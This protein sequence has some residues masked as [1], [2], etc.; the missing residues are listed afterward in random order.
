MHAKKY[1][2]IV[3]KF[4]ITVALLSIVAYLIQYKVLD[5][6]PYANFFECIA[7]TIVYIT[8]YDNV[9][10][11]HYIIRILLSIIG[12]V[13]LALLG[14]NLTVNLFCRTKDV[15]IIAPDFKIGTDNVYCL[16]LGLIN[17]GGSICNA[18]A[19][20]SFY[21]NES[22]TCDGFAVEKSNPFIKG[23]ASWDI[24]IPVHSGTLFCEYLRMMLFGGM[25]KRM[26][27]TYTYV[28][29]ATG[30]Q[31]IRLMEY[32]ITLLNIKGLSIRTVRLRETLRKLLTRF[33]APPK[34]MTKENLQ[35][36]QWLKRNTY[37]LKIMDLKPVNEGI[38]DITKQKSGIVKAVVDFTQLNDKGKTD[39]YAALAFYYEREYFDLSLQY[40]ENAIWKLTLH[41]FNLSK[42]RIEFFDEKGGDP[43]F[44]EIDVPSRTESRDVPI[45]DLFNSSKECESITKVLITVWQDYLIDKERVAMI[46]LKGISVEYENRA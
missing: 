44:C 33:L 9:T 19:K 2:I 8:G 37:P 1:V 26:I 39:T 42:I 32:D 22:R 24:R 13:C 27:V 5:S 28:D 31:S 21:D 17:Q 10:D 3:I 40:R 7:N 29:V 16:C 41:G 45:K 6:K 11:L 30:Q 35:F 4:F 36:K 25:I 43:H 14:A 12:L 38:I 34:L 23:G 46:F 18:I 20:I 15:K